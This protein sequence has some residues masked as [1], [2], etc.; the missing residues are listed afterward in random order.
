MFN[1]SLS[2][3]SQKKKVLRVTKVDEDIGNVD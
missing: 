2:V 3:L 1:G